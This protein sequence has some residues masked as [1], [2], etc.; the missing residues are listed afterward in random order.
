MQPKGSWTAAILVGAATASAAVAMVLVW[1]GLEPSSTFTPRVPVSYPQPIASEKNRSPTDGQL[2]Q[3]DGRAAD[4]PGA[5]PQFRGPDRD[6]VATVGSPLA[7]SWPPSGPVVRWRVA[8]GEGYA[9]A[10]VNDGR[11]YIIDYDMT[12]L[13]D[14]LR[15]LSLDDGREIWRYAYPLK[16]KRNHGMSRTV[17]AVAEGYVVSIGPKSHVL[18]CDATTGEKQWMIDMVAEYDSTVPPWYAG[19]CPL[20]DGGKVIH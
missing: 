19:Q 3:G 8:V 18:C 16:V 1:T 20:I 10:A 5:W 7:R 12:E 14:A 2:T 11:V 4:I 15:C 9:G 6:N 17:P 13:A